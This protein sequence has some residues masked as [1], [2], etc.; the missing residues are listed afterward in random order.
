MYLS[1]ISGA[2]TNVDATAKVKVGSRY[3]DENGYEYIYLPGVASTAAG[4]VVI[5]TYAT[6]ST[7]WATE[8]LTET[9]AAKKRSMAIALAAVDASTKYGWYQ[10]FGL[11]DVS[12]G[13][14]AAIGAKV[15]A[16]ATAGT[17]DDTGTTYINGIYTAETASGAGN[18]ECLIEYPHT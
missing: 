17:I 6:A 18:F 8:L 7:S 1:A 4:N 10:I 14:A 11:C 9:E 12:F 13:A 15:A 3:V 2:L 16:H 5:F